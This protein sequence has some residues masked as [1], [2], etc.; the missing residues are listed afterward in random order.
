MFI[1]HN[2][3]DEEK[4]VSFYKTLNALGYVAYIDWVN[5]KYDLKR[6]WCNATTA[7]VIKERIKQSH[8][9]ILYLS[10]QTLLSQWCPWELGYAD[11]LGKRIC[12]CYEIGDHQNIPDFYKT[13]PKLIL[14]EKPHVIVNGSDIPFKEWMNTQRTASHD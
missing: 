8:A 12:I 5:D 1:S 10:Q 4:I 2:S 3:K 11:A 14:S 6:E 7:K 9:F 13:Y